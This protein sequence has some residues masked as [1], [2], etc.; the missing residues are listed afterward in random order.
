MGVACVVVGTAAAVAALSPLLTGGGDPLPIAF[1][2]V[3][4]LAPIGLG[5]ILLVLMLRARGRSDRLR[6]PKGHAE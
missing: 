2:L 1:Y 3:S 5:L 4:F 6:H